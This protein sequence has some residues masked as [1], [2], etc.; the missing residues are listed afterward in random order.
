MQKS[1]CQERIRWLA[2]HKRVAKANI[3]GRAQANPILDT[4]VYQVEFPGDKVIKL[5]DNLVAEAMYAQCHAG[6]N[7]YLLID[8]FIDNW[9]DGRVISMRSEDQYMGQTSNPKVNSRLLNLLNVE[10]MFHIMK[11]SDLKNSHPVHFPTV[12]LLRIV[13]AFDAKSPASLMQ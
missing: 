11:L 12:F 7:K 4:R 9:K 6:G 10:R 13:L 1:C 3:K 8:S 2:V 5:N